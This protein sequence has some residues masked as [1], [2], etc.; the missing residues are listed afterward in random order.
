MR[1]ETA[2]LQDA[3]ASG[4]H[5]YAVQVRSNHEDTVSAI[6]RGKG[7]EIYLPKYRLPRRHARRHQVLNKKLFPGYLFCRFEPGAHGPTC[8]GA[9]VV[10]VPGV[11]RI[12]GTGSTPI[13]VPDYEVEGI[14]RVLASQ[15]SPEACPFFRAGQTVEIVSGPL[16]GVRGVL[17]LT[18]LGERL[19]VSV[20]LLQR[21]LAVGIERAWINPV[22]ALLSALTSAKPISPPLVH[23]RKSEM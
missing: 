14:Q 13:P 10:T 8:S 4:L 9:N 16:R 6:L 1:A 19:V 21:S 11:V 7:Y 18:G 3:C 2:L 15:L 23:G 17:L 12:V 20:E 5:W 22:P